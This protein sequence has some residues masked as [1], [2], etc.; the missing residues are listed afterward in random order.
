MIHAVEYINTVRS[1][2]FPFQFEHETYLNFDLIF[3][4]FMGLTV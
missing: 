1:L 2:D 3:Q 4:S